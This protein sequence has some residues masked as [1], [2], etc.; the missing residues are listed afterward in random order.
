MDLLNKS[1]MNNQRFTT[2]YKAQEIIP[3]TE[4]DLF[5]ES[6]KTPLPTTFRIAGI[7]QLVIC[8]F[9]QA[10]SDDLAGQKCR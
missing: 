9:G 4:W 3:D 6:L 10:K 8:P 2:Y 1:D 7:R 5:M